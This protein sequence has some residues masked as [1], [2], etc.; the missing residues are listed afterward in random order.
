MTT[1]LMTTARLS[2][3]RPFYRLVGLRGNCEADLGGEGEDRPG[4][5]GLQG[6]IMLIKALL[7]FLAPVGI[8]GR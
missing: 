8:G 7:A 4:G 2:C 1:E 5:L 3:F 6:L